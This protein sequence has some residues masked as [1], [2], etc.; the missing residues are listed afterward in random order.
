VLS[1][2]SS[3]GSGRSTT[4]GPTPLAAS[5]FRQQRFRHINLS[6]SVL[7]CDRRQRGVEEGSSMRRERVKHS[8][9]RA[10]AAFFG[11]LAAL[12]LIVAVTPVIA[13]SGASKSSER[14]LTEAAKGNF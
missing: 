9:W 1:I 8:H 11:L 14:R 7:P 13:G 5:R 2:S 12:G 4:A 10:R 6:I 3:S